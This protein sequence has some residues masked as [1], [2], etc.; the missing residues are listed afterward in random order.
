MA[1]K[2]RG[3]EIAHCIVEGVLVGPGP[4]R[5]NKM[6]HVAAL[7]AVQLV[8]PFLLH[9][10]AGLLVIGDRAVAAVANITAIAIDQIAQ[11][12]RTV[13]DAV[14]ITL[15]RESGRDACRFAGV[16]SALNDSG[17]LVVAA[18]ALTI[19]TAQHDQ[20]LDPDGAA[21]PCPDAIGK[22]A[23]SETTGNHAAH[24]FVQVLDLGS[25]RRCDLDRERCNIAGFGAVEEQ[26]IP[27]V[28]KARQI[29]A[30][31]DPVSVLVLDGNAPFSRYIARH[32]P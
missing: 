7:A 4:G 27:L 2:L 10:V 11:L 28:A 31:L 6:H 12:D 1:G 18:Q 15:K 32:C 9:Q 19:A 17:G 21:L 20:A 24:Q 13:A 29:I 23:F 8:P 25:P 26:M 3:E 5:H 22:A 30:A 16:V 14:A